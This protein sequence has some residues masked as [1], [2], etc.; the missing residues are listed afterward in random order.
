MRITAPALLLPSPSRGK[1]RVG[2]L[3]FV[4]AI[5]AL[6]STACGGLAA[7][8]SGSPT[9]APSHSS[10]PPASIAGH[11]GYP[12]EGIPPMSIYAIH[13]GGK[14]SDFYVVR[15]ILNQG[16]YTIR[17]I[18][19]GTYHLFA[20]PTGGFG[21]GPQRFG[22]AY[23]RAVLCGL[24]V[25]CTDHTPIDVIVASGQAV[26]DINVS[27]WYDSNRADYPV[28]PMPFPSATPTVSPAAS[29]LDAQAAATFEAQFGTG[30]SKVL[31]GAF[32]Q[33]P[34]NEA[35]IAVQEKHDGV[36]SAYFL[37]QAGS[38]T[39]VVTCGVYVFQD[40]SGW[41]PLNA[42]CGRYPAPGKSVSATFL[43]S[44]CINV[45]ANPGYSSKIVACLPVDTTVTID[46]GP[47]FV[48]EATAS[49]TANLNRLW[50]H[51]AGKGWMAHQYLTSSGIYY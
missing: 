7:S 8:S 28:V 48:Q 20:T 25:K 27:D 18:P 42:D 10:V 4:V 45:R 11:F 37:A 19:P 50:W 15:T 34:V 41:H 44:G 5:L 16:I 23:T 36:R 29:Y 2:R 46:G 33:C 26:T 43:G 38:N 21:Q 51:L 35:C 24:S 30:A 3:P 49:E 12:A 22:A 14:P 13:V 39:D 17:G 40:T 32:E 6:L 47:V 1:V 9:P 31:S